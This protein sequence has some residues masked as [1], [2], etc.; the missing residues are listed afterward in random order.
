MR[1][2][3]PVDLALILG[4][5]LGCSSAV[6]PE[7]LRAWVGRPAAALQQEWGLATREVEDG[8][9]RVLIYEQ[10]RSASSPGLRPTASLSRQ[11]AENTGVTAD[12]GGGLTV[13]VRSYLF[14]VNGEGTIVRTDTPQP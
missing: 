4:L 3:A 6:R 12:Q 1:V 7:V 5:A 13:Y 11:A 9:L 14:W 10:V 8:S 2:T